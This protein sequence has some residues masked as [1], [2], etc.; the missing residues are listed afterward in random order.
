MEQFWFIVIG[1]FFLYI[2][3]DAWVWAFTREE[4]VTYSPDSI[5][6]LAQDLCDGLEDERDFDDT[7][8]A[9]KLTMKYEHLTLEQLWQYNND[10]STVLY[11][12]ISNYD[13]LARY[14]NSK[15]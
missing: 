1:L 14:Y 6:A 4:K 12:I 15:K 11:D 10:D 9:L 2:L 13:K 3:V 7:L 5:E 8:L